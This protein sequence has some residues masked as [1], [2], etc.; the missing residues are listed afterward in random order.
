M[1]NEKF[2]QQFFGGNPP[3]GIRRE[4]LTIKDLDEWWKHTVECLADLP[5]WMHAGDER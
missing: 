5:G 4:S 1:Y 3:E 2:N